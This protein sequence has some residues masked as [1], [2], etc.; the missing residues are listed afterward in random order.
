[1]MAAR[2]QLIMV[3]GLAAGFAVA[4]LWQRWDPHPVPSEAPPRSLTVAPDCAPTGEVC[5]ARA[6]GIHLGFQFAGPV[7][8]LQPVAVELVTTAD[9]VDV[10]VDFSMAGMD[11]GRNR[12]RLLQANG[13]WRGTVTLPVCS[14]SRTDW[15]ATVQV[16]TGEQRWQAVFPFEMTP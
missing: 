3:A 9:A 7:R 15:L 2:G 1:M 8:G 12:Y 6:D 10:V 4:L 5:T 14:T 11:M 16:A 13:V